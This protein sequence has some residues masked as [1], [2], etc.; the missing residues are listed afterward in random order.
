MSL[1]LSGFSLFGGKGDK[2]AGGPSLPGSPLV[3]VRAFAIL[4]GVTVKGPSSRRKLLDVIRARRRK[5]TD[6]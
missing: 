4:G 6:T 3:L 5:P 2:R 1:Q